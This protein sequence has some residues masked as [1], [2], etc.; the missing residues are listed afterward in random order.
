MFLDD[1]ETE[2]YHNFIFFSCNG[3][4]L[5]QELENNN[6]SC[7]MVMTEDQTMV[8]DEPPKGNR[9][10]ITRKIPFRFPVV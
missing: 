6:E 4:D 5:P 1:S 10:Q 2:Q 3:V 8:F 7:H 9:T